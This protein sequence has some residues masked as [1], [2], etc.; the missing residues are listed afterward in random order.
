MRGS[1]PVQEEEYFTDAITRE[2]VDFIDRHADKPFFL[3]FS[4]NAVHSPVQA[5]DK[6]MDQFKH[7]E[8]IQRRIFAAM[9]ANLDDS[10]GG[11]MK[12]LGGIRV[13]FLFQ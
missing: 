4:Y 6:Y 12:K 7:I 9:L 2:S 1:Q 11:I 3:F 10:V 13:P 8:D 5:A